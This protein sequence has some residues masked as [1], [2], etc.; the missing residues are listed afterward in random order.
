MAMVI[1]FFDTLRVENR[2]FI[3]ITIACSTSEMT[4]GE[5]LKEQGGLEF[6]VNRRK[7]G[8]HQVSVQPFFNN[9]FMPFSL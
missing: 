1:Q 8:T 6:D 9:V 3:N 2:A 7:V 5:L 4:G